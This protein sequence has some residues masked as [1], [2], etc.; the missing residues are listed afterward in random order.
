MLTCSEVNEIQGLLKYL[1]NLTEVSPEDI[2]LIDAN[3]EPCA[4]VG[5]DSSGGAGYVLKKVF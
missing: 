4:V 3:G 1:E 2:T 5:P